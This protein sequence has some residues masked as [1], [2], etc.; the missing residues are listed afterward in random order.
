MTPTAGHGSDLE[1]LHPALIL[2]QIHQG[3]PV[4]RVSVLR[5]DV[6]TEE[7]LCVRVFQHAPQRL[8]DERQT[9]HF[10][11]E[12]AGGGGL[13]HVAVEASLVLETGPLLGYADAPCEIGVVEDPGVVRLERWRGIAP[14]Q[15]DDPSVGEP[16]AELAERGVRSTQDDVWS[17]VSFVELMIGAPEDLAELVAERVGGGD[18]HDHVAAAWRSPVAE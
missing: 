2:Q 18:E 9:I 6:L 17:V 13:D 15:L 16:F 14:E 12:Y 11:A 8:V 5:D 10:C 7:G 1:R 4:S 3:L